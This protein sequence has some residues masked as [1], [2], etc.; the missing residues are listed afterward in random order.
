MQLRKSEPVCV[1]DYKRV[2]VRH[3][4]ARLNYCRAYQNVDLAVY[5]HRPYFGKVLLRHLSVRYLYAE[6]CFF[7]KEICRF[8]YR[9][10]AVVQIK[11]L[12][13]ARNFTLYRI[14][15]YAYVVLRNI[16]GDGVSV[17]RRFRQHGNVAYA[18]H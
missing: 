3:V 16:G 5:K 18:R 4:N 17:M 13:A 6:P 15:D 11:T 9:V 7:V 10:N 14:N 1:F 2:A 8:I 12:S